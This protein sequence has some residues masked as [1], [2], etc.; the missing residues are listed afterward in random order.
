MT[1]LQTEKCPGLPA[2][3]EA[4]R[5]CGADQ[6]SMALQPLDFGLRASRAHTVPSSSGTTHKL[7]GLKRW[8][9]IL[10]VLEP[11]SPK[12]RCWQGWFLL[13]ARRENRLQSSLLAPVVVSQPGRPL[14]HRHVVSVSAC[15]H[16]AF[17]MCHLCVLSYCKDTSH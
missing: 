6:E 8:K 3:P 10:S 13:K 1:L 2:T 5:Q 14:T 4:R 12:S 16:R 15:L 9:F 7:D 11:R 17:P